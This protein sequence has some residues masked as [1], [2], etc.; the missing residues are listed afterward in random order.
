MLL[1]LLVTDAAAR[2]VPVGPPDPTPQP[3]LRVRP[4]ITQLN[5][6]QLESLKKGVAAMK[7][8][9][10][11]DPRSWRFQANMH[12]TTDSD[13]NP[14]FNQCEHGTLLFLAWHRGYVYYFERILRQLSGDPDLV[15][16]YW[17]WTADPVL[18][19]AF[20]TP[21]D[22]GNP[23]YDASRTINS[24]ATLPSQVVEDDLER[25][26][27]QVPFP[28]SGTVG[29]THSLE[30]SP[31]G[32]IHVL[33]GGNMS[34]VPTAANDPIFW[35]HHCNVDRLWDRW[36]GQAEGRVN[37][38]DAA[39]LDKTYALADEHG[40]TVRRKVR[41]LLSSAGLGYRYDT[42]PPPAPAVARPAAGTDSEKP[43]VRV[44]TTLPAKAPAPDLAARPLGLETVT[45]KLTVLPEQRD[46]L[47]AAVGAPR[48]GAAG[49][50]LLQVA[51]LSAR[52]VP[53]YVYAVYLDLPPGDV[54]APKARQHYVGT[55]SFF[56][57]V[58]VGP[59]HGHAASKTFTETFDVT[60]LVARLRAAGLWSPDAVRVTL[61]PLTPIAPKG[62]EAELRKRIEAS[63]QKAGASY[64][65]FHLVVAP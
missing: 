46:T 51:G 36:L 6:A 27:K 58:P 55:I 25:A 18:P 29:F 60:D 39:F 61:R 33:L 4:N 38:S 48:P 12:G 19:A 35:L 20:R 34:S 65:A 24:G 15:L 2:W 62:Q 9:P 3:V 44:A 28:A 52:E 26:L 49:K 41:D 7:A 32:A 10:A 17:D 14:L 50:I 40:K 43:P 16:P 31:H 37:P 22:A 8:L 57:K 64:Q 47:K 30:R 53:T 63:A 23:L 11:S 45:E 54:P 5:A 56:G 42:V 13:T 1:P 59:R 21:A